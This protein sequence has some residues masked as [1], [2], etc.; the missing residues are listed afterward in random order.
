[1]ASSTANASALKYRKRAPSQY[2][3]DT[4]GK[5]ASGER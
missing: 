3:R 2:C 1:M 5:M 4:D